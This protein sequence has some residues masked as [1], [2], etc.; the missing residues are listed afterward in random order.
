MRLGFCL[1]ETLCMND[2]TILSWFDAPSMTMCKKRGC[3]INK[4][5]LLRH[6]CCMYIQTTISKI[7]F[8]KCFWYLMIKKWRKK[9]RGT[10]KI[11]IEI[12]VEPKPFIRHYFN[13][14]FPRMNITIQFTYWIA[15]ILFQFYLLAWAI[16]NNSKIISKFHNK[17]AN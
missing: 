12:G 9:N 17:I 15:H 14:F 1:C 11:M 4:I 7:F 13:N 3:R 10:I 2:S 6:A 5:F 8:S 16:K